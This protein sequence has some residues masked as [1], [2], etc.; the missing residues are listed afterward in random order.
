MDFDKFKPK[1]KTNS[2]LVL[3][4]SANTYE[5]KLFLVK[6]L[7]EQDVPKAVAIVKKMIQSDRYR[8]GLR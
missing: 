6:Y 4:E 5:D 8:S 3:L 2:Q 7:I 1:K